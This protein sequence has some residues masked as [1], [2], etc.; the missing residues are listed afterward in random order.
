MPGIFIGI[1]GIGGAIVSSVRD[2]LEVKVSLANDT[3]SAKEAADQF[4]FML[5]DT[6]KDGVS[7]R[8]DAAQIFDVPEGKDK[9]EVDGKIESWWQDPFFQKWWPAKKGGNGTGVGPLM[10]GPYASGAGQLRVK[11]RLAYRIALTGLG[12]ELVPAVQENLRAINAVL[13]PATGVRTVPVYLVCSLGGGSGSGMVLT[14]A[15]HLRQELPE[16]C[17]IIGVF[18]LASVTEMGPGASDNSSVWA[19]TDSALREIDYCQRVAG[20]PNN[21]LTPFFQWPGH[22]NVIYGKQRPFEYIYIFGRENQSGQSLPDFSA[23]SSLIAESLVAE[24]FSSLIDE[25]LQSAI[26]GPHSQFIMQLQARP[27]TGGRPTSY[28]S[29]AVASLVFPVDR[30]ERHLARRFA[31]DVLAKMTDENDAIVRSEV[32]NFIQVNA[33]SWSGKPSF[34]S[35]FEKPISDPNTHKLKPR[36]NFSGTVSITPGTPFAK[37]N[38]GEAAGMARKARQQLEDFSGKGLQQ[39]YRQRGEEI[40]AAFS[41]PD[42]YLRKQVERWLT[43]GGP[44]ALGLAF[45]GVTLLRQDLESEWREL[46]KQ[47]EGSEEDNIQGLKKQLAEAQLA[48]DKAIDGFSRS[49]GSGV[50][51]ILDR[52]STS[53]KKKFYSGP[54]RQLVDRTTEQQ[55]MLA[56]RQ[57]YRDLTVEVIRILRVLKDLKDNADLLRG[58]LE[59]ET[60][61][62]LGERGQAG[63]LDV[64]VLDDPVLLRHHFQELMEDV[65]KQGVDATATLVTAPPRQAS[66]PLVLNALPSEESIFEESATRLATTG[67]VYETFQRWLDPLTSASTSGRELYR[68]QL[69]NA[70]VSDGVARVT[71]TVREMSIWDALAAECQAR[72]AL[73]MHDQAVE[74]AAREIDSRRRNA[75]NAGVPARNWEHLKLQAFIRRRLEQCQ[76]RVRPFWNLNG[77]MTAN[78][79]HPYNFVVLATDEKA[80][81]IAENKHGIKGSLDQISQLLQAG[82]PKWMP[83]QDR[84][85]LYSRE[86]VAPLFYLDTR[87]LKRMRDSSAQKGR[88]KFLYV[89]SRFEEC[90]DP[91]IQ[92]FESADT[93]LHYAIGMGLVLE[94]APDHDVIRIDDSRPRHGETLRVEVG[95]DA[96]SF[97]SFTSLLLDLKQDPSFGADLIQTVDALIELIPE[98]QRA[99]RQQIAHQKVKELLHRAPDDVIDYEDIAVLNAIEQ[100]INNR[101]TYGQHFVDNDPSPAH[102]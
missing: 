15:Q 30:V 6:W 94:L 68:D 5:V 82:T 66:D 64:A 53:A 24:S 37:A 100:A 65:R 4:R 16:Y 63:V 97:P 35:E 31:I 57:V 33:L 101:M 59:R 91:V 67:V 13:G 76:K 34:S 2:S 48:Y 85:V 22:G 10:A 38:A 92:P 81:R 56:A 90:V 96:R 58:M 39:H 23:Y 74:Q 41:G 8:Y 52:D 20:T 40:A 19:N 70:I 49:F 79:G 42:G 17:P 87:E 86:G 18:P 25:G 99:M 98:D 88:D 43:D 1:G 11:G 95:G 12:R 21:K 26:L 3:P 60:E 69:D 89:D 80:Y 71:R 62:D 44:S 7:G 77:L 9:F 14:L 32:D 50:R 83:G 73:G 47:Y 78:Y 84:I 51:K 72:D 75:E 55:R 45:E 46:N 27:E 61:N 36:P 29:A 28:A 54:Y 102:A 93:R